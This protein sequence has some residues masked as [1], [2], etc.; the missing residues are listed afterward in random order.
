[1]GNGHQI[2]VLSSFFS[3]VAL[4]CFPLSCIFQLSLRRHRLWPRCLPSTRVSTLATDSRTAASSSSLISRL[5]STRQRAWQEP[6]ASSPAF[7]YS[8]QSREARRTLPSLQS[9]RLST[10][11]QAFYLDCGHL[12]ARPT[13][14]TK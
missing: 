3:R 2:H 6:M 4:F 10:R 9:Q 13:S 11:R 14:I 5:S 1:M 8:P 12:L 7:V